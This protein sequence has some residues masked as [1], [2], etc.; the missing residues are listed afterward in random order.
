MS[1]ASPC[2]RCDQCIPQR[3]KS[4][5]SRIDVFADI[6]ALGS[7]HRH[8]LCVPVGI[9][10]YRREERLF[11]GKTLRYVGDSRGVF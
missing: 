4:R 9:Y 11:Q 5:A 10:I 2:P 6:P 7:R 1:F 3:R 8:P